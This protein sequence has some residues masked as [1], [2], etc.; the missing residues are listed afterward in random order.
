MKKVFSRKDFGK[1][2]AI[3]CG[4]MTMVSLAALTACSDNLEAIDEGNSF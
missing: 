4:F 1:M 3:V 2:S